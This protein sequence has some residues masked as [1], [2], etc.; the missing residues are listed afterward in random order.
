MKIKTEL[1]NGRLLEKIFND[2]FAVVKDGKTTKRLAQ[3]LQPLRKDVVIGYDARQKKSVVMITRQ[4]KIKKRKTLRGFIF[5]LKN[6]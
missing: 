4:F 6:I 1:E 5:S 3:I 2:G